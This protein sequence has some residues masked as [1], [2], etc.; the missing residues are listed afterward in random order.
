MVREVRQLR[1]ARKSLDK[2]LH[3][4]KIIYMST[5]TIAVNSRVYDRLA[6]EKREGESFSKALDRLL[7]AVESAH[8]GRDILKQL[9]EMQALTQ[10]DAEAMLAVV[11]ENRECESWAEHDLR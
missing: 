2:D 6:A 10:K 11:T 8:T 9:D 1:L 5:K 4:Y 3:T 7:D